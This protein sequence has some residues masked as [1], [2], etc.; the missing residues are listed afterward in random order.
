MQDCLRRRDVIL[1]MAGL[2]ETL[3]AMIFYNLEGVLALYDPNTQSQPF[4][5]W[6]AGW[7][8]EIVGH[9]LCLCLCML[10]MWVGHLSFSNVCKLSCNWAI[11]ELW[12]SKYGMSSVDI[13][14]SIAAATA[15]SPQHPLVCLHILLIDFASLLSRNCHTSRPLWAL[16]FPAAHSK[17][18]MRRLS[19][20]SMW[21]I[22]QKNT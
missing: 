13:S 15:F 1:W 3:K 7:W 12:A 8:V 19:W 11:L 10:T 16:H 21:G 5:K 14:S 4:N 18:C 6:W 20:Y 9:L 2:H 17:T 22:G